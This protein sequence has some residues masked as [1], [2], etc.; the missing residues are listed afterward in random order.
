MDTAVLAYAQYLGIDLDTEDHLVHIAKQAL[1]DLPD[2]W[3][4]CIGEEGDI[5]NL[6]Y[7]YNTHYRII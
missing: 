7:F 3:E 1:K 5:E 2:G 6:P 4:V